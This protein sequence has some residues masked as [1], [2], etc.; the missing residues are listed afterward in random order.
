VS[1]CIHNWYDRHIVSSG[2]VVCGRCGTL[3]I[4]MEPD[5]PPPL[6]TVRATLTSVLIPE[7]SRAQ[8][9]VAH[10][11]LVQRSDG[12]LFMTEHGE[13]DRWSSWEQL[14]PVPGTDGAA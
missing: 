9:Y 11:V 5:A 7:T 10:S 8:Q 13:Y 3:V 1:E 6:T 12:V 4:K 14:P 2:N